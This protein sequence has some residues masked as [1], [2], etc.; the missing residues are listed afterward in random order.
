MT[1]CSKDSFDNDEV[2]EDFTD[3]VE[4]FTDDLVLEPEHPEHVLDADEELEVVEAVDSFCFLL[5]FCHG[6]FFNV[7]I[8]AVRNWKFSLVRLEMFDP[9]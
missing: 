6:Q 3:E 7:F 1:P 2:L 5:N 4:V 8:M 9:S